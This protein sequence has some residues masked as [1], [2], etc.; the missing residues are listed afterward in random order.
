MSAS[1]VFVCGA[2]GTQGGSLTRCLRAKDIEVHA[3]ARDPT[4]DKAKAIEALG[5]KLWHGDYDNQEAMA[6]AIA[7]CDA[8]FIN[9]MP[10]LK[11]LSTEMVWAKNLLAAGKAAGVKHAIYSSS[12]SSDNLEKLKFLDQE[13]IVATVLRSKQSIEQEVRGAGYDHWTILRPGNFMANFL[14]PLVRMYPGLVDQGVWTTAMTRE[15]VLPMVDTKTIG[16]FACAA[17]LEPERFSSKQI[18]Y[19]DELVSIDALL[20]ELSKA[21]GRDLKA[22]YLT[23]AE[24]EEQKAT[25]IFIGGQLVMR[26][27]SRLVNMHEVKEWGIPMST[28]K[29]FLVREKEAVDATYNSSA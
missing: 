23:D 16:L 6:S 8:I 11:D 14:Q 29:E 1:K 18:S 26:D 12:F 22:V 4:S 25:N 13:G 28:F 10:N 5:V 24:I 27:M 20:Q 2:T 7:G 19:A 9:L 3:L 17:V 21:T 15:T